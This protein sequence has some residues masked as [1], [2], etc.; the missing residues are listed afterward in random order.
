MPCHALP[1]ALRIVP[2][3]LARGLLGCGRQICPLFSRTV[4]NCVKCC[5]TNL[6]FQ[7]LRYA[8]QFF[9]I[10]T[11]PKFAYFLGHD[12]TSPYTRKPRITMKPKYISRILQK[13]DVQQMLK[14]LR[15]AG[16]E[17][18]KSDSGYTVKN[19][20]GVLLFRAMNGRQNYL[21]RMISDL[22]A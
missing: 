14:A 19:K 11:C 2:G 3:K 18:D 7:R 4:L 15:K 8:V 13:P 17:V 1:V 9:F 20:N 12:S 10:A 22:F 6:A 16:L 5:L 21:V